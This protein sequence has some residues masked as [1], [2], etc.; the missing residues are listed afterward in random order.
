MTASSCNDISIKDDILRLRAHVSDTH[1]S[2]ATS[3]DML[4]A[5][6]RDANL[7]HRRNQEEINGQ[8]QKLNQGKEEMNAILLKLSSLQ[9]EYRH[10]DLDVASPQYSGLEAMAYPLLNMR[11]ILIGA[12]FSLSSYCSDKI[13]NEE[14]DFLVDEYER[15]AAFCKTNSDLENHE[16]GNSRPRQ[17]YGNG[18]LSIH[19]SFTINVDY[20]SILKNVSR[21]KKRRTVF[22]NRTGRLEVQFEER[23]GHFQ[24]RP[25][26]IQYASF[27]YLPDTTNHVNSNSIY[28]SF[29]KLVQMNRKPYVTRI[30]REV[31]NIHGGEIYDQLTT[32][33][34]QDD[35][36]TVQRMLS[37]GKIRPWDRYRDATG[38]HGYEAS[39]T[40][41][42]VGLSNRTS[43]DE[44][45]NMSSR[46]S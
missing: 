25:S 14:I 24:N 11:T 41:I 9:L 26:T 29:Q 33:L 38:S 21:T 17:R 46:L 16:L 34:K 30:L 23:V 7:V 37:F 18:Q 19:D 22:T 20:A 15:L 10:I 1:S 13:S 35:I 6:S 43:Q 12:M 8:L 32:A 40:L 36:L 45:L 28:A 44:L 3:M 42:E 39:R 31:R 27:R 2:L 5:H 4:Q